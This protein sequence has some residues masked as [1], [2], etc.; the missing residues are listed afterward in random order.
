MIR[1]TFDAESASAIIVLQPNRS[2]TWR[3]NLYL[4][5]SL[6]LVSLSV[7]LVLL[8]LGYW[9]ILLFTT[10]EIGFLT[11]CLHYCVSR[12][13]RQEVLRFSSDRLVIE[14]GSRQP[15]EQ[16]NVQRFFA[17]FFVQPAQ[18]RG[19]SKSVALRC[20]Y[21]QKNPNKNR[22]QEFEVGSFLGDAEKD[23]LVRLLQR[24]IQR[25]DALPATS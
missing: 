19:Q 1:S 5:G 12:T 20:Q 4:I 17:R 6:M 16:V 13:H 22:K 15:Q 21:P 9:L 8:Y 10:L 23:Q 24:T 3:A 2:W 11:A 18:R 7:G 25:L 14:T